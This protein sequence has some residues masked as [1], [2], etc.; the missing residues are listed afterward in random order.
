[1]DQDQLPQRFL[2][3]KPKCRGQNCDHHIGASK[4]NEGMKA[5]LH[6][7]C[8]RQWAAD[9]IKRGRSRNDGYV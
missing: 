1:M 8:Q 6:G 5:K 2:W 4:V 3:S 9:A 7:Q